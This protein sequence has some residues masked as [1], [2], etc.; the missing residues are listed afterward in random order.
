MSFARPSMF[1]GT[2]LE[3]AKSRARCAFGF[4]LDIFGSDLGAVPYKNLMNRSPI[5]PNGPIAIGI[6]AWLLSMICPIASSPVSVTPV[7]LFVPPRGLSNFFFSPKSRRRALG[8]SLFNKSQS[9]VTSE[10]EML[11]CMSVT[12]NPIRLNGHL[13][14]CSVVECSTR[15]AKSKGRCCGR[16]FMILV[17]S[18]STCDCC[19]ISWTSGSIR[20]RIITIASLMQSLAAVL[21]LSVQPRQW[22]PY[23]SSLLLHVQCVRCVRGHRRSLSFLLSIISKT[24]LGI[25]CWYGVRLIVNRAMETCLLRMASSLWWRSSSGCVEM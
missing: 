15:N 6:N 5:S 24:S 23:G 16:S 19:R 21:W 12:S 3:I 7:T 14:I 1:D 4:E 22:S 9:F 20:F 17:G 13:H 18:V 11:E 10:E 25:L 2:L 8:S